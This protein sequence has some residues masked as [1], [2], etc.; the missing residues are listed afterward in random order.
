MYYRVDEAVVGPDSRLIRLDAVIETG[1]VH[2]EDVCSLAR[3]EQPQ[4]ARQDRSGVHHCSDNARSPQVLR[5]S[6]IDLIRP[7]D[8]LVTVHV[9][10]VE[11]QVIGT[12][13]LLEP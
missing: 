2:L 7:H 1:D 5:G 8:L 4:P 13:G 6:L 11:R 9:P 12:G 3:E 10:P